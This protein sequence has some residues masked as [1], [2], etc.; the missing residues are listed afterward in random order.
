M[1]VI[2]EYVRSV[3]ELVDIHLTSGTQLISIYAAGT[4]WRGTPGRK[5]Q[6]FN[7]GTADRRRARQEK[8]MQE[9]VRG[10]EKE[11]RKENVNY[12]LRI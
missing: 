2:E 12:W 7:R 6:R 4:S 9:R 10:G 11:W 5:N 8:N 1:N 3:T